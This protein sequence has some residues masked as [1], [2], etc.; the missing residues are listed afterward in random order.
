[1]IKAF[2]IFNTQGKT[3]LC[4]FY[5]EHTVET[6]QAILSDIFTLVSR[7]SAAVC[8]F[9]EGTKLL[10]KDG[11]EET[12]I[13]YRHYATLYFVVLADTSESELGILDLIQVFVESLDRMFENVCEL[14][15]IFHFD[16][17]HHLLSEMIS[18]G[19]VLET[20]I[21]EMTSIIQETKRRDDQSGG[22]G[23]NGSSSSG[24]GSGRRRG[25]GG[26]FVDAFHTAT[27]LPIGLR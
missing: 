25:G 11:A 23:N 19:L 16:D 18:G 14:D 3:R 17:V 24:G 22:S 2:L 7:R 12:R 13:I 15:L 10:S 27:S 1:M 21:N 8:N 9:L 26:S 5:E 6:Q 20:S 4:R